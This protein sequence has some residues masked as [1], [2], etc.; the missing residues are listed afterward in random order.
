[1]ARF[2]RGRLAESTEG[3]EPAVST[4]PTI[5]EEPIEFVWD[6]GDGTGPVTTG[7]RPVV[8]HRFP[9]DGTYTIT[10]QAKNPDGTTFDTRTREVVVSNN[11]PAI[12]YLKA[13]TVDGEDATVELS[14]HV[15]DTA[16]DTVTYRWEF[17]DG[18]SAEGTDLWRVRHRFALEGTYPVTLS[19]W[20]G[21]DRGDSRSK[22]LEV[23]VY[24]SGNQPAGP[25]QSDEWETTSAVISGLDAKISGGLE[26]E[27]DGE[28]RSVA[29]LHLGPVS[30]GVCRFLF[31]A[32]DP[33]KLAHAWVLLDLAGLPPESGGLYSFSTPNIHLNLDETAAHYQLSQRLQNPMGQMTRSMA[34][35]VEALPEGARR[36][37]EADSG[38]EFSDEEDP[39]PRPIAAVSPF[40]YDDHQGFKTVAGDLELYFVPYDRATGKFSVTL[41]NTKSKP[42]PGLETLSMEGTFSLDLTEARRGGIMLYE[43][44]GPGAL[45]IEKVNP[46]PGEKHVG[47][48]SPF[49]DVLFDKPYDPDT[50]NEETFQVGYPEP[51]GRNLV[52]AAGRLIKGPRHVVF[53][54][55]SPLL[56]GVRYTARIKTGAEGVLSR[57]RGEIEDEDGS[58]WHTWTFETMLDFSAEAGGNLACHLFQTIREPRLIAGKSAVARVYADWKGHAQVDEGAQVRSF[59]GRVVLW[60][61]RT[62]A[63]GPQVRHTFVRPDLWSTYGIDTAKA[64]H[65]AN[66]FGW[67]PD[68]S[69]S[70]PLRLAI[71]VQRESGGD[72]L[73]FIYKTSC[74]AEMWDQQ[75][76]LTFDYYMVAVGPFENPEVREAYRGDMETLVSLAEVYAWQVL[77]F[78]S[79]TGFDRGVLHRTTSEWAGACMDS[80]SVE[81]CRGACNAA[82]IAQLLFDRVAA[83]SG[84]DL[85]VGFGALSALGGGNNPWEIG[86]D[87]QGSP[88]VI[89]APVDIDPQYRDRTVH[90]LVHEMGHALWLE[91]LP[92]IRSRADQR[93][94]A[95]LRNFQT[96]RPRLWWK[97]IEGYSLA[98]DG[99]LGWNKSSIEGNEEGPWLTALMIPATVPHREAFIARHHYLDIQDYLDRGG[100]WGRDRGARRETLGEPLRLAASGLAALGAVGADPGEGPA[101][102]VSGVVAPSGEFAVL[103]PVMREETA[104]P[105]GP[106]GELEIVL[107]DA[108]GWAL[109]SNTTAPTGSSAG[110]PRYFRASLP[111]D[112][113]AVAVEVRRGGETLGRLERSAHAPEVS[114]QVAGAAGGAVDVVWAATDADG[115][116]LTGFL[117]YSP[118]GEAPWSAVAIGLA[119][120]GEMR[121]QRENLVS[122]PRPTLRVVMTDGFS[123][124]EDRRNAE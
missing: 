71:Q 88:G 5:W 3:Y 52:L 87:A 98:R 53:V 23:G 15:I 82:C 117:F 65:T 77:P 79:V 75:P 45:Q 35:I 63:A 83:A 58:G 84:A 89:G 7:Q 2:V 46:S 49:I 68:E 116:P 33:A 54:P 106:P 14:A 32:W 29:G 96:K 24:G 115:G 85:V 119:D 73:G 78:V 1:M 120:S 16:A 93:A 72:W 62:A 56:D 51:G 18:E 12:R 38:L 67:T 37:L 90:A 104:R 8:M 103:G 100:G 99:A 6:F 97:G 94:M 118:T 21:D 59:D 105:A 19:V 50:L 121:V 110:G 48:A 13:V 92:F 91:H 107:L 41:A 57:G 95:D 60:D 55:E 70:L 31:T 66:L 111:W 122:G 123:E 112:E 17:G 9:Q 42:P 27:L 10:L 114:L 69:T 22:T 26:T 28:I 102:S 36:Q 108:E 20:N 11:V 86:M 39:E 30:S 74:Q 4:L 64:K 43:R 109:A 80:V 40:G 25:T 101:V 47:L 113:A 124:A 34:P 44:C 81:A 61:D 76:E